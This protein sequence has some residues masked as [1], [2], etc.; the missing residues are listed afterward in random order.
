MKRVSI[1]EVKGFRYHETAL[2]LYS[3]NLQEKIASSI[4]YLVSGKLKNPIDG[5]CL[6]T[7]R[8]IKEAVV[9]EKLRTRI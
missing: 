6:S 8:R 1:K 5:I 7:L 4:H 9:D 3:W 2:I